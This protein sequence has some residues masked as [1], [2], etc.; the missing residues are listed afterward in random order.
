MFVSSILK[1]D[2]LIIYLIF[3]SIYS[4]ILI[5][6]IFD[7]SYIMILLLLLMLLTIQLLCIIYYKYNGLHINIHNIFVCIYYNIHLL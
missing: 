5:L 3:N 2:Q 4:N 1:S 6:D 7:I